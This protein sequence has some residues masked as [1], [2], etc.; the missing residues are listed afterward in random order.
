VKPLIDSDVLLYEIGFSSQTEETTIED[1]VIVK[2]V[3]PQGWEFAKTL[4]DNR[5]EL[6]C[7]EVEATER[8]L[9]FL[10]NSYYISRLLN[11]SRKRAEEK[12][13]EYVP[14]FRDSVAV[15]KEY[16]GGRKVEK[17]F[18]YKNLINHVIATYNYYVNEDGLEA[19]DSMCAYQYDGW[20]DPDRQYKTII[21]SRDKDVRQCPGWHYSWEC[22]KQ[23][24]IGPIMVDE[25]GHLVDKNAG[26]FNPLTG[27][28][29]PLKVFGTGHKFFY[30][31]MLT[32]DTVD[33]V[34]SPQGCYYRA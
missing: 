5:I 30:Y 22:G 19:D 33:N 15:T 16:K 10:T 24:S 9:L 8:P 13:V 29:L 20:G 34:Q 25:L 28:K 18:H 14:N 31:Q 1:G 27:K 17:P 11:K 3:V 4:F 21:C 7:K 12:V 6:I 32:G 23:P 2:K 26:K